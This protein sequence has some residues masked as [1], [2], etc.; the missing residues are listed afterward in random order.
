MLLESQAADLYSI[1]GAGLHSTAAGRLS[2]LLDLRGPSL[3][4]D[5]ACATSLLAVHLACQSIRS[6]ESEM[7]LVCGANL[8]LRPSYTAAFARS[9]LMSPTA[10]CKFGDSSADG[11]VRSEGVL[12]VFLKPLSRAVAGRDRGYAPILGSGGSNPR[13]SSR[14]PGAPGGARPGAAP[15]APCRRA[16]RSP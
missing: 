7:A 6:G 2:Y 8:Q 1:V 3:A 5:A 4:V 10:A 15:R 9:R 12:A 14:S 13:P 16:R 11:F